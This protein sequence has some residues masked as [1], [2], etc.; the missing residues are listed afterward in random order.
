MKRAAETAL[1]S[2]GSTGH[3]EADSHTKETGQGRRY[4]QPRLDVTAIAPGKAG[5]LV[6]CSRKREPK[7]AVDA[8]EMLNEVGS[9]YLVHRP[10][11]LPRS[12]EPFVAFA[13]S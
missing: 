6:S 11:T 4:K 13:E 1:P 5:V 9:M 7:A 3:D 8:M 12:W 2:T 10:E